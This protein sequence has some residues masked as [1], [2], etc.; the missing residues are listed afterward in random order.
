MDEK[1]DHGP[2]I[3]QAAVRILQSDDR[4]K[5]AD[6]IL[7][8]EHQILPRSVELFAQ[9]RLKIEGRK[10]RILPGDSWVKKYKLIPGVLYPEGY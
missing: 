4:K 1:M 2:I 3:L 5:L 8:A 9:N 7:A 6:R 10:V